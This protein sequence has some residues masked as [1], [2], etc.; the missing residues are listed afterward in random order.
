MLL[1]RNI[2]G[3]IQNTRTRNRLAKLCT[4]LIDL[5]K[6]PENPAK[7]MPE[8]LD[9]NG[10]FVEGQRGFPWLAAVRVV[11][12]PCGARTGT[13]TRREARWVTGNP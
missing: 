13:K 9:R 7:A 11:G 1:A 3:D 10:R 6:A 2:S 4:H 12:T 8:A 5:W